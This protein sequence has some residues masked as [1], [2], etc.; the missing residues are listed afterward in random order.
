MAKTTS[1]K[2]KKGTVK[3]AEVGKQSKKVDKKEYSEL[4]HEIKDVPGYGRVPVDTL[5]QPLVQEKVHELTKGEIEGHD[6]I[7]KE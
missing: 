1:N 5:G 6:P 4:G 2:V 7:I 3:K